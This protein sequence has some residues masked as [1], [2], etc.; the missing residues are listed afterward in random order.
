M[1]LFRGPALFGDTDM[2]FAVNSEISAKGQPEPT[3]W[4]VSSFLN[5]GLEQ[6]HIGVVCLIGNCM[7][8]AAF[9]AIQAPILKRYPANLTV[10]AYSYF[11]GALLMVATAFF[12]V[13]EPTDWNLTQSEI[14]AVIYAGVVASALNYAVLTWCNKILGPALVSLYNPLQPAASAFLSRVFLGSPIYLGSILGGFF[15]ISGLYMVTWASYRE[16]RTAPGTAPHVTRTSEPLI[17]RDGTGSRIGQMFSGLSSS[18]VKS[19]D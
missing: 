16:R 14:L 10:T 8:M 17:Y 6:W 12:M 3:G 19:A 15:I 9:L 11:F 7:C 18:S 5:L 1:V 13:N 2:D 4:L